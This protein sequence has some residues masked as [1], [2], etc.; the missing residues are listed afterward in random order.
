MSHKYN[1]VWK[2]VE[3]KF[4]VIVSNVMEPTEIHGPLSHIQRGPEWKT[5]YNILL[6]EI[7]IDISHNNYGCLYV[8]GTGHGGWIPRWRRSGT[9][10]EFFLVLIIIQIIIDISHN[11]Y[12][13]IYVIGT[14]HG[15]WIPRWRRSG[16][17]VEFFFDTYNH[18]D[19]NWHFT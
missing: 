16:T 7:I 15:G 5:M 9:K 10:V 1:R 8:I 11:N 3:R 4:H 2:G 13:Y 17:K 6:S 18:A 19:Y 12:G 14:G